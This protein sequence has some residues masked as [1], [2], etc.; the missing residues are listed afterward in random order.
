MCRFSALSRFKASSSVGVLVRSTSSI[1]ADLAAR[2]ARL[3]RGRGHPSYV[4]NMGRLNE[5]KLGNFPDIDIWVVVG[6]PRAIFDT[7]ELGYCL[8][9]PFELL[10]AMGMYTRF[11]SCIAFRYDFWSAR[12]V[13]D[14]RTLLSTLASGSLGA[15]EPDGSC[16]EEQ[17]LALRD[18]FS[19]ISVRSKVFHGVSPGRPDE[20]EECFSMPGQIL[21]GQHGVPRSYVNT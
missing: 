1:S 6:C 5:A 18:D 13:L 14:S 8:L 2:L 16:C 15:P 10:C 20:V 12:Y 11:L 19:M 3:L 17:T 21:S 9:T 4:V 7:M